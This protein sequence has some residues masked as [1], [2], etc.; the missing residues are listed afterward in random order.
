MLTNSVEYR[1][2]KVALTIIMINQG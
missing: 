2:L 1:L